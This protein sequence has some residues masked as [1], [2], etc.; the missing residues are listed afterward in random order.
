MVDQHRNSTLSGV[1][2]VSEDRARMGQ[3]RGHS[4]EGT[5]NCVRCGMQMG[6]SAHSCQSSVRLCLVTEN[7]TDV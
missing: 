6:E 1:L 2:E 7:G 4:K 5:R 3:E